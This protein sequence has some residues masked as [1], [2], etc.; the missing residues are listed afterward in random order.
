[1]TLD[2]TQGCS[3]AILYTT[4]NPPPPPSVPEPATWAMML[5]GFGAAGTALRRSRRKD[6]EAG[7][8]RLD[9]K[10]IQ[11]ARGCRSS[12][13]QFF[14][15]SA[16]PASRSGSN[17]GAAVKFM[18]FV[19]RNSRLAIMTRPLKDQALAD[20]P[21]AFHVRIELTVHP[22]GLGREVD[23]TLELG[24]AVAADDI[25]RR[26]D[27]RRLSDDPGRSGSRHS[28]PCVG[29]ASLTLA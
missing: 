14:C 24:K 21:A 11:R 1:M 7:A 17:L 5:L 6:G 20:E 29:A 2:N 10:R 9:A 16:G 26:V 27:A 25:L 4:G 13:R 28:G 8:D 12:G 23:E 19:L 3:N 18:M 15:A 22:K